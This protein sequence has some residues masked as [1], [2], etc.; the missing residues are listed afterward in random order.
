MCKVY[1]YMILCVIVLNL[2]ATDHGIMYTTTTILDFNCGFART[3]V[4]ELTLGKSLFGFNDT[5]GRQQ[6]F[7]ELFDIPTYGIPEQY[8]ESNGSK[9]SRFERHCNDI[10]FYF[11]KKWKSPD[12]RA[13]AI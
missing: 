2:C 12:I 13:I 3:A 4:R 11:N 8:Y 1:A 10:N 7:A 9:P 6:K 5:Q